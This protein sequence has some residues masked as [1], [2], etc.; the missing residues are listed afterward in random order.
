MKKHFTLIELLVVI[1][2]IAILAAML[3]PALN[4]A[5]AKAQAISCTS[6]V[7][8]I[9]LAL[10]MYS[11]DNE[12]MVVDAAKAADFA[13]T[14]ILDQGGYF[15]V[16]GS[17]YRTVLCP[18]DKTGDSRSYSLNRARQTST[19]PWHG[20]TG[21]SVW[22]E[23]TKKLSNIASDTFMLIER[24]GQPG[25]TSTLN[26]YYSAGMSVTDGKPDVMDSYA[27][28]SKATVLIVDGSVTQYTFAELPNNFTKQWTSKA[29]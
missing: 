21:A 5:R 12:D 15:K 23:K 24:W 4:K 2:I 16:N 27:H 13:W 10:T 14:S 19:G 8:Q 22:G 1:A 17:D 25:S 20:V 11:Q 9:G 26:L 28:S 6:Q 29:D 3:L 7:K 18:S